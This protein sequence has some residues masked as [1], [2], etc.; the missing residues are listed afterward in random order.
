MDN[1]LL[2]LLKV[3]AGTALFY[4][5]YL[6]LF[7][8]D[9]FYIRNRILLILILLLPALFPLLKIPVYTNIVSAAQPTL[10]GS[11]DLSESF[12]RTTTLAQVKSFDYN[13]FLVLIY[14]TVSALLLLRVL[15]SLFSTYKIIKKGTARDNSFPRVIISNDQLPPFSFFP[16]AVIPAEDY[17][18]GNYADLLDHEFAH[19]RQ[20]HSFDLILSEL[21]IAFQWFNPFVWLIKR[22]IV[23]NHEYLADQVSLSNKSVKEYQYRLLNF[24]PELKHISLA[25]N[26]NS[27]IKNRIIMIN[28]K[29]TRKYAAWKSIL[30]LPVAAFAA[31]AFATPEYRSVASVTD[32]MK[33]NEAPAIIQK[34]LKGIVLKEDG[35]PLEGA[36]ISSKGTAGN[37]YM[38]KTDKDGR[39]S[40][41]GIQDDAALSF[42]CKGYKK[43]TLKPEFSKEMVVK[44]E[45][46]PD[47]KEPVAVYIS[48]TP[49]IKPPSP[50][51]VIDG[52]ITDNN[53]G[54][55]VR[56]LGY[57][58]GIVKNLIDKEATD[59]YGEKGAN[60]VIEI[61]TRKKALEMGLKPPFPRI[62]PDDFPTFQNQHFTAFEKWVEKQAIYPPEA[63]AKGVEGWVT[64][65]F[66]VEI[67]GSLSN[68]SATS[69]SVDPLL[70]N[71]IIRVVKSSPKWE[72]P[73]NSAVDE[74][75]SSSAIVRFRLPNQIGGEVPFVVVEEMPMYPGGDVE[76]LNFIKNNSRYPDEAKR[77]LIQGRVIIRFVVNKDGNTEGISVLR[78]VH[79]LLDAEA[80]RVV[81][82][83]TGFKPG[84]QGGVPV[85][86]WYMVP[87]TFT[88]PESGKFF[89]R[90]SEVEILKF[91]GMNTGY[92][93]EAKAASDTG[94][95]FVVVRL[96]KGGIVRE[97]KTVTER[98]EI[99]VPVLPEVV[100][101]GYPS[102]A[103]PGDIRAGKTTVKTTGNSLAAF[104]TESVRVANT[105][106]VNEIPDWNDK[107]LEFALAFK[108]ILK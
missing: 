108:F 68:I 8:K 66:N 17:K 5:C 63:Q 37:A 96:E 56:G 10:T 52:V 19:I 12:S 70:N 64:V 9:T 75:L 26:F 40:F 79:P 15:I 61:T 76:L 14:F 87:V 42:Y 93:R 18:S 38:V 105:L 73:K 80:I 41:V 60:N 103:G 43:L 54:E 33:V 22:S 89:T 36:D 86:V 106:T 95:V 47:F 39:F 94:T 69:N 6:L 88:L 65:R 72:S 84:R 57:N 23:L 67:D 59:K 28:K 98:S 53:Y 81:S 102:P 92:P 48:D 62:G 27:L 16:Y 49:G 58:M 11:F 34:G 71:E 24:Q 51:V 3:S 35:K 20:G 45:R 90:T 7:R 32:Q 1:L 30:I 25:H 50:L 77:D 91:I 97:C 82:S 74:P 101:V 21:F 2:Y 85:N 31:Y 44:M 107:D 29:P 83:L 46:D 99:K 78:G 4:L 104:Q 100:I 55:A 13:R